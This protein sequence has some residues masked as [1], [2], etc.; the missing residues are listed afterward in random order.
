MTSVHEE[1]WQRNLR[2]SKNPVKLCESMVTAAARVA[3]MIVVHASRLLAF[4]D[5]ELQPHIEQQHSALNS[6]ALRA[7][8]VVIRLEAGSSSTAVTAESSAATTATTA[9]STST[10]QVI[11]TC[12]T[13]IYHCMV[14]AHQR[15]RST[16]LCSLNIYITQRCPGACYW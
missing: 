16:V 8:Q 4:T 10:L 6:A 14:C 11:L 15:T 12:Y 3:L 1:S 7:V 5:S 13:A 2:L 9:T